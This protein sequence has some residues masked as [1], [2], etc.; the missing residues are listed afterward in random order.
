MKIINANLKEEIAD[1]ADEDRAD[2]LTF[3][4]LFVRVPGFREELHALAAPDER[5]PPLGVT[6]SLMEKWKGRLVTE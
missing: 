6:E 3:I 4:R 5:I 2:L 1:L